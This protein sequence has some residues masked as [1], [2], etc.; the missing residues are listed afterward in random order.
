MK[1]LLVED[2][3]SLCENI[4][5]ILKT[6][7][8]EV[9]CAHDGEEGLYYIENNSCDLVVLDW[10]L[11]ELDGLSL[12]QNIRRRCISTPVLMLSAL[13]QVEHRISGLDAGADDYLAKPF[14]MG[15][16]LARV[17][18][19][20]RRPAVIEASNTLHYADLA[21]ES[22]SR[23]L[24]GPKTS[25]HLTGREAAMLALFLRSSGGV[26]TRQTLFSRVWGPDSDTNESN[27]ATYIH[28]LRRRLIAVGSRLQFQNHRGVGFSLPNPHV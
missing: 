13:G 14:E 9:L 17:R 2:E 22:H 8:Y 6:E 1:I 28:F 19:L 16:L 15:E 23:K 27:I 24:T 10:M 3:V 21:L 4:E 26:I 5:S 20:V 12:L 25:V 18:A 7:G 11:P